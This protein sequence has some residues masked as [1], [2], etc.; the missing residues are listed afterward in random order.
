MAFD[1]RF[2]NIWFNLTLS[3]HTSSTLILSIYT[4]KLWLLSFTCC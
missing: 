2:R 3:Q 1:R 4:S